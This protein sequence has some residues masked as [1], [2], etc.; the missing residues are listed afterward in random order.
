MYF[1]NSAW[2]DFLTLFNCILKNMD[3][4]CRILKIS[5]MK[6]KIIA[7]LCFMAITP[8]IASGQKN[9]KM[10]KLTGRVTDVNFRPVGGAVILIDDKI[11]NFTTN[12]KGYYKVRINPDAQKIS[13]KLLSGL[14]Y[15][16]VING[17]TV[18][19]F[20]LPVAVINVPDTNVMKGDEEINVG[21]GTVKKRNLT[22]SV[23][24]INGTNPK[25]ASYTN[26]YDMLK[27]EVPGVQVIGKSIKV[28]GASSLTLSTEPLF[29]VDGMVVSSI[30]NIMPS[31][32]RSVE[33]L[34]GSS[35]S[36]YGSRGA[37]GVILITLFGADR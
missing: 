21:Y 4:T 23:S 5:K 14:T 29:V 17:R 13:V 15:D 37:N 19:N 8:V 30:D 34:K 18:V 9:P 10:V 16:E 32:V 22:T 7:L 24:K 6:A 20:S 11:T 25:Y 26:I 12:S 33:V 1:R 27:G 28:Q 2:Q 35:A 36:I 31:M 3:I